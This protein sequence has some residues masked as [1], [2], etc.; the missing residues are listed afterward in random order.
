AEI[1][2]QYL[3]KGSKVYIEGRLRTNKWTDQNNVTRWTTEIHADNM[4][5]LSPRGTR[6]SVAEYDQ[7]EMPSAPS[8]SGTSFPSSDQG[9]RGV[10]DIDLDGDDELEDSF[11]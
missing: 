3:D 4:V 1:C 11:L 2:E 5:M 7:D 6:E 9:S 10:T 8:S